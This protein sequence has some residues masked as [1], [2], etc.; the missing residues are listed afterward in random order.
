MEKGTITDAQ[1]T[2]S[3]QIHH[4]YQAIDARPNKIGWYAQTA[5]HNQ[6]LQV[7]L[8][9]KTEVTGIKT[10]GR[11]DHPEWVVKYSLSF[12]DDGSKFKTYQESKVW[13]KK[14]KTAEI[15]CPRSHN[16]S[17]ATQAQFKH[18][19]FHVRLNWASEITLVTSRVRIWTTC[20]FQHRKKSLFYSI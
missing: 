6:W 1:I 2:A 10:W 20:R 19:T 8:G 12:G 4:P 5:D 17:I 11:R 7:D 18:W 9:K 13:K 16:W 15:A 14:L 3:S